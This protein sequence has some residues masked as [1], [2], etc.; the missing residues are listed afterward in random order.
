[1]PKVLCTSLSGEEGPH[2]E[3]LKAAGFE[4]QVVD[5]DVDL[6]D[7]TSF[8]AAL[9]GCQA[10]IAGAEP[11]TPR[12]LA[13]CPDLRVISRTGVG[14]DAV[15]LAE[16][17]RRSIAVS[18]TPGVN[19]DAVAEHAVALLMGIARGFPFADQCVRDCA[20]SRQARPRVMGSTLGI[21]GLGRIGQAMATR[22]IGLGMNVIASDPYAPVDF[23]QQHGIEIVPLDQLYL[24]SDYISLHTPV[25]DD[26]KGMI[27]AGTIAKMKDSVVL[28]NTARGQLIDEPDLCAALESGKLRGAGLDVFEVEPLP[29]ESPLLHTKNVFL[30]NHIAGLDCESFRDMFSMAADTVIELHSGR[31]PADRIVNLQARTDWN[32]G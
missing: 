27:N 5:R 17:D 28:I 1:M 15:D 6:W 13:S 26:T 25:T 29:A 20:W 2:F 8:A 3:L 9:Q 7:E 12:L 31:W 19:H 4:C 23:A 22:G 32:W 10:V 11:Y 18:I 30:S 14:F 16:C 24:R 21:V